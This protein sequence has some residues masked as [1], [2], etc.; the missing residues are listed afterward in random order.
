MCAPD[1]SM[2][3]SKVLPNQCLL[4]LL[5]VCEWFF[6]V[7]VVIFLGGGGKNKAHLHDKQLSRS[8]NVT[9]VCFL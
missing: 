3:L 7:V 2:M 4:L 8:R 5:F 6:V 1:K 9:F